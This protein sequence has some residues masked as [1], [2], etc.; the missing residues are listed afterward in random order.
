M[1]SVVVAP[2]LFS[3]TRTDQIDMSHWLIPGQTIGSVSPGTVSVYSGVDPTPS[4][5]IAS[6]TLS[7]N[8]VSVKYGNGVLGTIYQASIRVT[9][10]GIVADLYVSFYLAIIPDLP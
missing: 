1:P 10:V 9:T 5:L 2:K 7:G 4:A 3:E 8:I 6:V